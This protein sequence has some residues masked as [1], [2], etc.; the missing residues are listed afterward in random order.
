MVRLLKGMPA[1]RFE[2]ALSP[3]PLATRMCWNGLH[4]WA[5]QEAPEDEQ[6][7]AD[8]LTV[9]SPQVPTVALLYSVPHQFACIRWAP[10]FMPKRQCGR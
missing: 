6:N 10:L 8:P 1:L 9:P 3:V 4:V 7:R 2:F 5:A